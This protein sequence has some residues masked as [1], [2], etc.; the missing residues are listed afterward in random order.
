MNLENR[1]AMLEVELAN[2]K[3]QN[4]ALKDS[5]SRALNEL[6]AHVSNLSSRLALIEPSQAGKN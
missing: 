5:T 1:I 2:M 3:A 6:M 4:E